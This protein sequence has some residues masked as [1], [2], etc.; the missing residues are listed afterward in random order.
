M[1]P[2]SIWYWKLLMMVSSASSTTAHVPAPR[3]AACCSTRAV[4][5]LYACSTSA[6]YSAASLTHFRSLGSEGSEGSEAGE[7]GDVAGRVGGAEAHAAISSAIENAL[8]RFIY[9]PCFENTRVAPALL[10]D[11]TS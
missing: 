11:S 4:A 8:A 10:N 5:A 2:R 7:L 3:V 1:R 9:L 6:W